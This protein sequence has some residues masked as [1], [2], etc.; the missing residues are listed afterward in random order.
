M[1]ENIIAA[2]WKMNHTSAEVKEFFSRFLASYKPRRG[3]TVVVTPPS[4][5]LSQAVQLASGAER[6]YIGAQNM[7]FEAKGAFTGELS[8]GML[9]DL[10]CKYVILGHSERRHVFGET[11]ELIAKKVAAALEAGLT[12]IFCIGELLQEREADRTEEVVTHQLKAVLPSLNAEQMAGVV[13]A[14]EPVWAIGTGKTATPE[15]AE[16][17]HALV[18]K[19]I[20]GIYSG[21]LADK[22][23]ILYGG[24][25]KPDNIDDLM[26]AVDIDGALVGGASLVAESFLRLVNFG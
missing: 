10:G 23:S 15:Q 11:D 20:A 14:Y 4:C 19:I 5:Y 2:N 3:V 22:V 9:K 21:D 17:V 16:E 24:S 12:P 1:R 25:V 7:Y 13:I 6:V 18:R 26:T 8:A